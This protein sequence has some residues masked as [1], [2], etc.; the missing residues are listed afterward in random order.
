MMSRSDHAGPKMRSFRSLPVLL[1]GVLTACGGGPAGGHRF[2]TYLEKGVRVAET[3]G[4]P[5]Y[6][7]PLFRF[8][9]LLQLKQDPAQEASL[10][11]G[12]A[13]F[14][15]GM[16]GRYYVADGRKGRIVAYDAD[17]RYRGTFGRRG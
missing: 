10:L 3:T 11:W 9:Q 8:E 7:E 15:R 2:R 12:V 16:D 17:G 14:E 1:L 6:T 5:A 13:S 4:G